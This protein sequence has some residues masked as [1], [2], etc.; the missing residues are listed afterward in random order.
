[1]KT[2]IQMA[3][4]KDNREREKREIE[5]I[6]MAKTT[7]PYANGWYLNEMVHTR[8]IGTLLR[9]LLRI[10]ERRGEAHSDDRYRSSRSGY[11]S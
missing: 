8:S 7:I 1:M 6:K 5:S 11:R 3:G 9:L 10:E 4:Y 2:P